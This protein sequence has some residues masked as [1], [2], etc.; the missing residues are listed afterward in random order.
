MW[1]VIAIVLMTV[2]NNFAPRQ[3][4]QTTKL[5]YSS[6]VADVRQGQIS[7]VTISGR[8]ISGKRQDGS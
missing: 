6:F 5:D 1:L 2:F 8:N 3:Q 7:K 4:A